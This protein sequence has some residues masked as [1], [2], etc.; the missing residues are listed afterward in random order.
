MKNLL[1]T[2][3]EISNW[4]GQNRVVYP[5]EGVTTIKGKNGC[6]KTSVMSAWYWLLSGY[7][8]AN[9]PQNHNLFDTT[10]ELTKDTPTASVKA[11]VKID[12]I[13][14]VLEK[15]V[16]ASFKRDKTSDEWVKS[17][18]D[19]YTYLI[20][21]IEV[22][23][24]DFKEWIAKNI[25]PIDMITFCMCGQFFS[26]LTIDDKKQ[27][28]LYLERICGEINIDD[29]RERDYS[30]LRSMFAKGYT[31][32]KIKESFKATL[33]SMKDS[34]DKLP[35]EIESKES[36]IADLML[37]DFVEIEKNID[38]KNLELA[39]VDERIRTNNAMAKSDS[40]KV[41]AIYDKIASKRAELSRLASIHLDKQDALKTNVKYQI[42]DIEAYNRDVDV[43]NMRKQAKK[44]EI[45]RQL[46]AERKYL[47]SLNDERNRL[48]MERNAAKAMVFTEDKCAYCGQELP[49]D[50]LDDAIKAF[51]EKKEKYVESI[52]KQGVAIKEKIQSSES[53]IDI[54]ERDLACRDVMLE[55]KDCSELQAELANIIAKEIP[56]E[57]MDEYKAIDAEIASLM[58]EA[59]AIHEKSK[60]DVDYTE[61]KREIMK[62]IMALN[63]E[64]GKQSLIKKYQEEVDYLKE[65]RREL[66][67]ECA[68]L[69]GKIAL[70]DA[71]VEEKARLVSH[72]INEKLEGCEIQMWERLKNGDLTPAC[73]VQSKDGVKLSTINYSRR[74]LIEAEL[75]KLFCNAFGIKMPIF[76][77]EANVFD[78]EHKPNSNGWQVVLLQASD[79]DRLI[80]E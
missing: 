64:L 11:C 9:T 73:V 71:F 57:E 29:L 79:D 13:E 31:I 66:G 6:G 68:E 55:K 72:R 4:R 28:R 34:L 51:D 3:I 35:I 14:W 23:A 75:Q 58:N 20:D 60:V 39:D 42:R 27:A 30:S 25:C 18:S 76:Y 47:A 22:S 67:I 52:I 8:D 33:K 53:K 54:L 69:E 15:R 65:K 1:L 74:L 48:V 7:T 17:Q 46:D 70:C 36:V 43:E 32:E 44:R 49:S 45:E 16:S 26:N 2:K 10:K 5:F 80:V 37:T 19:T 78:S 59:N 40:D 63:Q 61:R 50:M 56:F 62:D 24:T 41:N 38:A 21:G 12:D 77:D